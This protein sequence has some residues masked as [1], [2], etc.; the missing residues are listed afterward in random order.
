MIRTL[1]IWFVYALLDVS[2]LFDCSQML[3]MLLICI[4]YVLL[5]VRCAFSNAGFRAHTVA[6]SL[7]LSSSMHAFVCA[8]NSRSQSGPCAAA[9]SEPTA[10]SLPW[11]SG[12]AELA[13]QS[14]TRSVA[15]LKIWL[16]KF[17]ARLLE[18]AADRC[19]AGTPW[20]PS[21]LRGVSVDTPYTRA[22]GCCG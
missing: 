16:P 19:T 2:F 6:Y 18:V 11:W 13:Q 9:A 10:L 17:L 12:V 5:R 14:T 3:P 21:A 7:S 1:I 22:G 20:Q 4:V 8:A 15:L